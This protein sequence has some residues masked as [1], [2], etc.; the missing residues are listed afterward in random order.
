MNNTTPQTAYCPQCDTI[1]RV[2][3]TMGPNY[4][5]LSTC[6]HVVTR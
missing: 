2:T 6:G 3:G 1:R 4:L 5:T